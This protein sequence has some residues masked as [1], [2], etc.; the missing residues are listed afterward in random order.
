MCKVVP[1]CH[2]SPS[3]PLRVAPFARLLSRSALCLSALASTSAHAQEFA[4]FGGLLASGG[5]HSY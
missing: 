4:L 2:L 3:P 1:I 5:G